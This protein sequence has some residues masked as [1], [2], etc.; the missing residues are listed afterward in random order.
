VQR[1]GEGAY[2]FS[3]IRARLDR[4]A[5]LTAGLIGLGSRLSKTKLEVDL[6]GEGASAE[7]LGLSLGKGR[8][9]FDYTTLQN[10][11]APHTSSDLMFKAALDDHS[12]NV[13]NGTVRIHKGASQS[14]ANQTS[15]NLLLSDTAK[16]API[17]V[18]EIEAY[19]VLRCS[20]GA[21]AGP[22][23]EEQRFYLESRGIPPAEAERLLVEAFFREVIDRLPVESLRES[24]TATLME[25][26]EVHS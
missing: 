9:H 16:A 17:P 3:T 21:T 18:L 19:D 4:G 1:W 7:L 13:W 26:V 8:Q 15:R 14:E 20:H 25:S 22:L 24:V 23:D 6:A 5:S 12:S 10:H 11:I 2:A